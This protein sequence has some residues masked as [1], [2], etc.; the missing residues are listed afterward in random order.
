[1]GHK[2]KQDKA[3][4]N[5]KTLQSR[6]KASMKE[7]LLPGLFFHVGPE[8]PKLVPE[9]APDA[10]K[11]PPPGIAP[12][13]A[14]RRPAVSRIVLAAKYSSTCRRVLEY[15]PQ[16]TLTASAGRDVASGKSGRARTHAFRLSAGKQRGS[17]TDPPFGQA[18]VGRMPPP[19][20]FHAAPAYRHQGIR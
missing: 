15:S 6:Q 8:T 13:N 10:P 16:S 18:R 5:L 1:M 2:R 3:L 9:A 20:R 14:G 7:T 4:A 11:R 19:L 12:R 17:R